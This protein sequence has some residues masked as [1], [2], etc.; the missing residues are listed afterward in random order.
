MGKM[1]IQL[2]ELLKQ[3][4]KLTSFDV[5]FNLGISKVYALELMKSIAENNNGCRFIKGHGQRESV[6]INSNSISEDEN[7]ASQIITE[8]EPGSKIKLVDI[9]NKFNLDRDKWVRIYGTMKFLSPGDTFFIDHANNTPFKYE[10][11]FL[12]RRR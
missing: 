6:L 7:I 11:G 2:Q 12:V 1:I 4:S 3:R 8:I 5:Q 10:N 9:W